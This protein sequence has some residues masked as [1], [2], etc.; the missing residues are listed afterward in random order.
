M[1]YDGIVTRKIT[2]EL[3]E[4]LLGGKI[5]KISQPSKNDIVFN[6]YS[7]GNSYKLLLS[8]NNNEAR[9]N[10]TNIKYENPDVPPNFCMIL[11]KHI[12]QGKIVDINQK[13][14]D[15]VIIFSISSID[16]MGYDTSKKLIIEIMG[17]YSNIILVDDDF[18]IIDSIKRVNDKMSSVRQILPSLTYDFMDDNKIDISRDDFVKDIKYL[19]QR[20][21]DTQV[22]YKIFHEN[23]TGFSPSVGKELIYRAGIDERINWGLVS[24]SEKEVLNNELFVLRENILKNKLSSF[25][26]KNNIKIKD[27][28][29]IEF[30]H[31]NFEKEEFKSMSESIELFY[32]TNKTNDRLNQKKTDLRKKIDSNIKSINKK[33][34]ILE[35]N[36]DQKQTID[37]FKKV[38][39]LLA[40]NIYKI[41]KGDN[42]VTVL[43]YYNNNTERV[44]DIDPKKS[45]WENV[46]NA[47]ARS[48][49]LK[50][51]Y[52]Y[53]IKDLPKQKDLLYYLEQTKDFITRSSSIDDLEDIRA[54][55]EEYNII[56]RKSNKK[57]KS[58]RKSKPYHYRT[59]NECDIYV[60]KNSKQNDY[61]TLKLA[62]KD[63]YWF[64]IKDHPGSHVVLRNEDIKDD[65][66]I[67]A[68][69]LAAINSSVNIGTKI[70]IDYTK[71]KN[72]NKPKGAK[73]GMVY[74]TDFKTV[75]IDTSLSYMDE[76]KEIK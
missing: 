35:S 7:M 22:P 63:D 54:E 48:K 26:Y 64:H 51:S 5:Q 67:L 18:K 27:Y 10:I 37:K 69:Y 52:D 65:D 25:V 55:L 43:D 50:S 1:S 9:V 46:D 39:D 30:K 24:E 61:I 15:R 66:I 59:K 34:K 33:I 42:S 28:H 62:N 44:I 19:D 4:K 57:K 21:A 40:A 11:R 72:V 58:S 56:K 8:A 16:E 13:G 32:K 68:A 17:K 53:A 75:T 47:Y 31:L 76:L 60:G 73:P 6:I 29:T 41:D 23:Y 2:N 36:L 12:N 74:Y 45:P 3:K 38:G 49:K 70:D 14:L 71:K 20:L